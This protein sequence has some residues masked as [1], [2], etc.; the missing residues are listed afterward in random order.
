[1]VVPAVADGRVRARLEQRADDVEAVAL[2]GQ[3]QGGGRL[4][5]IGTA[6]RRASV[7]ISAEIEQAADRRHVPARGSPGER[8]APVDVG[9]DA[10]AARDEQVERL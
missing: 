9:V 2:C 10:R 7:G 4:A 6:E 3:M 8:C 1:V 5:V